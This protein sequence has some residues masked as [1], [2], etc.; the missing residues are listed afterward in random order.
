MEKG[1]IITTRGITEHILYIDKGNIQT[2]TGLHTDRPDFNRHDLKDIKNGK[3][4]I[5]PAG[6][7]KGY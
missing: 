1:F 4:K 6:M 7:L 2:R 3:Y 5:L